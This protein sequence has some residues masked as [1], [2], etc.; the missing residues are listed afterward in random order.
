MDEQQISTPL[1]QLEDQSDDVNNILQSINESFAPM[2]VPPLPPPPEIPNNLL[3]LIPSKIENY[4]PANFNS[5]YENDNGQNEKNFII[6]AI[7]SNDIKLACLSAVIFLIVCFI[8]IEQ[9]VFKYIALEKIPFANVYL[10]SLIAGIL[11]Y[12]VVKF[13]I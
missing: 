11:F 1:N 2:T 10:K 4:A 12:L 7:F 3:P 8:P 6:S 5:D 13:V 9:M